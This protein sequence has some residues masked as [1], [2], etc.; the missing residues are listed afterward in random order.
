[1]SLVESYGKAESGFNLFIPS[2]KTH[3]VPI[4]QSSTKLGIRNIKMKRH[5]RPYPKGTYWVEGKKI[6]KQ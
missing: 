4:M 1:M 5:D 6:T 3:W 2:P